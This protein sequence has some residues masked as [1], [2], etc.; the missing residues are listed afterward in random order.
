MP[1]QWDSKTSRL[2]PWHPSQT[3]RTKCPEG[4]ATDM[5]GKRQTK[6]HACRQKDRVLDR[7]TAIKNKHKD[8]LR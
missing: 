1:G 8:H 2:N 6:K 3:T 4:K 7:K 5:F